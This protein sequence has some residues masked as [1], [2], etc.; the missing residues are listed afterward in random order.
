MEA[1]AED[2][3][4]ERAGSGAGDGTPSYRVRGPATGL[5]KHVARGLD[6]RLG[7]R[8]VALARDG[9]SFRLAFEDGPELRGEAAILTPPVP[10][11]LDLLARGGLAACLPSGLLAAL[12]AVAYHP[13]FVLLLRLDR[14]VDGVPLPGPPRAP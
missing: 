13:T 3:V 2:G 11:S 10:Q 14:R 5:A 7:A 12:G 4:V 1:W 9:E 8:A 6:V